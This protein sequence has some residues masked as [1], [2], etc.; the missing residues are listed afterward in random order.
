MRALRALLIVDAFAIAASA[1][2]SDQI[3][4]DVLLLPALLIGVLL[5]IACLSGDLVRP[6]R[7]IALFPTIRP[8]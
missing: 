6:R 1:T 7:R 4:G 3:V 5:A 8:G 2:F